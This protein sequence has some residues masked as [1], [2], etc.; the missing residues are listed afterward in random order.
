MNVSINFLDNE[1]CVERYAYFGPADIDKTLLE[2]GGAPLSALGNQYA[3]YV[4][5][6]GDGNNATV[7]I[8][9]GEGVGSHNDTVMAG[10]REETS[11]EFGGCD[12]C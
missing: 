1:S 8:S 5:G 2:N 12:A 10:E 7:L 6:D 9:G 11:G 4:P 3:F